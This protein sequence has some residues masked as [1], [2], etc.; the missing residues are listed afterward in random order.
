VKQRTLYPAGVGFNLLIILSFFDPHTILQ[1]VNAPDSDITLRSVD[2]VLFKVHRKNLEVHS[3]IF[4]TAESI[5]A[6]TAD[7]E[8]EDVQLSETAVVLELLLQFMYRQPQ[9][10]LHDLPFG[11]L[12]DLV[13]AVDKYEVYSAMYKCGIAIRSVLFF[14]GTKTGPYYFPCSAVVENVK[15]PTEALAILAYS[16]RHSDV[17][18]MD[19]VAIYTVTLPPQTV[20]SVLAHTSFLAWVR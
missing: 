8:I 16:T 15:D 11:M 14:I 10:D 18:T 3:D 4:A 19:K 5:S 6:P 2:S 1:P 17:A 13:D 12:A 20:F 7:Q 9:P